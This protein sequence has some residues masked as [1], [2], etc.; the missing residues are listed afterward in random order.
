MEHTANLGRVVVLVCRKGGEAGGER[1]F[2]SGPG[3]VQLS[4]LGGGK[5]PP[6][7]FAVNTP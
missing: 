2:V 1:T 4:Q 6:L 5:L 7:A 3:K